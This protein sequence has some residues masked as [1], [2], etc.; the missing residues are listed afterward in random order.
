MQHSISFV[1]GEAGSVCAE[2][3]LALRVEFARCFGYAFSSDA[4]SE[5]SPVDLYAIGLIMKIVIYVLLV[6]ES[7]LPQ[8]LS[9]CL[10]FSY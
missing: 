3:L 6:A 10:V 8:E 2:T 9:Q 1:A 5:P 4:A 7:Q